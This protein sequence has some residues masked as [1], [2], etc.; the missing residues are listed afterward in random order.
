M[1]TF[2]D[3]SEAIDTCMAIVGV[4]TAA[5]ATKPE[6]IM[7]ARQGHME[8]ARAPEAAEQDLISMGN[9]KLAR[10]VTVRCMQ[11]ASGV[12]IGGVHSGQHQRCCP[13]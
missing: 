3:G 11:S 2:P 12:L 10:D 4:N 13:L 1:M 5:S 7:G 8:P 6:A 9:V